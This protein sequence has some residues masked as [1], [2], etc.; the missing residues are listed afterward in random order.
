MVVVIFFLQQSNI[1]MILLE[2]SNKIDQFSF[3][4]NCFL[5]KFINSYNFKHLIFL[6]K[7]TRNIF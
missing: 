1:K 2:T 3:L 6:V 5:K 7:K 4:Y